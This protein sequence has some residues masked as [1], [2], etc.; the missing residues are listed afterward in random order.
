[1]SPEDISESA[2]NEWVKQQW[3]CLA[4][5]D[6]SAMNETGSKVWDYTVKKFK[7]FSRPQSGCH[8]LNSPWAGIMSLAAMNEFGSN[9]WI[10]N[11]WM[12]LSSTNDSAVESG[13]NKFPMS[14]ESINVIPKLMDEFGSNKWVWLAA[15][16]DLAVM[17]ESWSNEAEVNESG[18][19]EWVWQQRISLT[20]MNESGRNKWVWQQRTIQ[21][22]MNESDRNEWVWQQRMSLT[23]WNESCRNEWV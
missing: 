19:N 21:T 10:C 7:R 6:E 9:G 20:W 15:M 12:S 13:I 18:R 22:G 16:N 5:M 14:L 8:W 11:Q 1:M 23:G 3:V 17:D 4:A 2:S